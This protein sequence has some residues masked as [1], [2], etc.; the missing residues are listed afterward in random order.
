[1]SDRSLIDELIENEATRGGV[2]LVG[3]THKS[4]PNIQQLSKQMH[5][6]VHALPHPEEVFATFDNH[7]PVVLNATFDSVDIAKRIRGRTNLV[8]IEDQM[9][10]LSLD[11]QSAS[12]RLYLKEAAAALAM[13]SHDDEH[14]RYWPIKNTYGNIQANADVDIGESRIPNAMQVSKKE[15]AKRRAAAKAAKKSRK[16]NRRK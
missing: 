13:T 15:I 8:C 11:P 9:S 6:D 12:E 2:L 14:A 3:D 5:I 1:M 10:Y 16:A 4:W 7:T